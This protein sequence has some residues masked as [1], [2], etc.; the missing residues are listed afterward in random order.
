MTVYTWG[1]VFG[2]EVSKS[3]DGSLTI[4]HVQPYDTP[5][6]YA[7]ART[8]ALRELSKDAVADMLE[9]ELVA[10]LKRYAFLGLSRGEIDDITKAA[11]E[12]FSAERLLE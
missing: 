11:F 7:V 8:S 2:K 9:N 10:L 5:N 6:A 12:R 3:E 1:H 4:L